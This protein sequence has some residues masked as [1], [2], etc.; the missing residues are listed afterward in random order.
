MIGYLPVN[1]WV[2]L[3]RACPKLRHM[4]LEIATTE[5]CSPVMTQQ[6]MPLDTEGK[7]RQLIANVLHNYRDPDF[8]ANRINHLFW[9][10][11]KAWNYCSSSAEDDAEIGHQAERHQRLT[12][13]AFLYTVAFDKKGARLYS[14]VSISQCFFRREDKG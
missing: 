6:Y 2:P 14:A 13:R 10:S 8:A 12:S 5:E 9:S 4:E 7:K 1:E 3:M 11:S